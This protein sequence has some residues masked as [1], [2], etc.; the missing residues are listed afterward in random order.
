MFAHEPI[1][2]FLPLS[3]RFFDMLLLPSL[4]LSTSFYISLRR[5]DWQDTLKEMRS[6]PL[7]LAPL[8]LHTQNHNYSSCRPAHTGCECVCIHA[9][10]AGYMCVRL[11]LRITLLPRWVYM[12]RCVTFFWHFN[13]RQTQPS[14]E[15][16]LEIKST[17]CTHLAK[18]F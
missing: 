1:F 2:I 5:I 14:N 7:R 17:A 10:A 6:D 18:A 13:A 9:C 15:L 16:R 11:C 4:F 8:R 12:C 3:F